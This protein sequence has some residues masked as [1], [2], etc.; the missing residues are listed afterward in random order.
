MTESA[1]ANGLDPQDYL[2]KILTAFSQRDFT[3]KETE[4]SAYLPWNQKQQQQENVH[5]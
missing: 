2:M 4:L 1:K 3:I 5:N